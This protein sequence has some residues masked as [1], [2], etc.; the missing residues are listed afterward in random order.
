MPLCTAAR[1]LADAFYLAA[2]TEGASEGGA[3]D[4]GGGGE[5][6]VAGAIRWLRT[7]GLAPVRAAVLAE[8][9]AMFA[10]WADAT[11]AWRRDGAKP[12]PAEL[13]KHQDAAAA[14][15]LAALLQL[16]KEH[17]AKAAGAGR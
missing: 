15:A 3:G 9:K 5:A 6:E 12:Q 10:R 17:A 8:E 4:E 14:R 11:T 1:A 2:G 16:A 7:E 13:R